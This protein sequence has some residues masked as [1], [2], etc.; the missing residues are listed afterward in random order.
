M[1]NGFESSLDARLREAEEAEEELLK[2]QPLAEEAP[3]L[4]L[5]KAKEQKRQERERAKQT[6]MQVVTQSVRTASEKQT[7][8][9]SLLE[10]AGSAVQALYAAVKEIDRLRQEAAESM[11]IVDRIDYEIEVEEGEQ[12]EISL[13]RDPRGLAY[14][15]AARHGD[16]RVKDLLEEMDPAFGYLKDCDLTQPLYR[17]VA[18]FVLDHAVSSPSVELMPVAES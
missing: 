10:T 9:P 16:V 4:R 2:L 11:A 7:R 8:V 5:E 12:H 18:K 1:L 17:D 3:R 15:L 13:D 6:A 14:A